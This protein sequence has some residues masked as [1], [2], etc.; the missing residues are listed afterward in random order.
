MKCK[1]WMTVEL[2]RAT[3]RQNSS[4]RICTHLFSKQ[5]TSY[6][7]KQ[8]Q[9]GTEQNY[10]FRHWIV[11][12]NLQVKRISIH[13]WFVCGSTDYF[14][15]WVHLTSWFYVF[16]LKPFSLILYFWGHDSSFVW[17]LSIRSRQLWDCRGRFAPE[18]LYNCRDRWYIAV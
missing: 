2:P 1:Q 13:Y 10:F 5:T 12:K 4:N 11:L 15:R 18:I 3:F 6:E 14:P 7:W 9:G 8:F 16:F 17:F